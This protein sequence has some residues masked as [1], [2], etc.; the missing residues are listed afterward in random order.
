MSV[1]YMQQTIDN[2]INKGRIG[3][4]QGIFDEVEL[5]DGDGKVKTKYH[6]QQDAS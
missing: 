5:L 3:E 1:I 4:V 6:K 2:F